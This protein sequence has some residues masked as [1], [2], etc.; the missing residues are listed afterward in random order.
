[1]T[2]ITFQ[3][4]LFLKWISNVHCI[5]WYDTQITVTANTT[6]KVICSDSLVGRG[7][8]V[9]IKSKAQNNVSYNSF[10]CAGEKV[11]L[12]RK[13]FWYLRIPKLI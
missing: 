10:C 7:E 2:P 12:K 3:L 11:Q 13:L 9:N 5:Q 1:M 6:V 4:L 8:G